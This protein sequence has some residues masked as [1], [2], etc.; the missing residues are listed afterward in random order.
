MAILSTPSPPTPKMVHS[1]SLDSD[2]GGT[3]AE[4]QQSTIVIVEES[5]KQLLL[6][7]D[8]HNGGLSV[9]EGVNHQEAN[10]A[11]DEDGSHAT[12]STTK[13]KGTASIMS[14]APLRAATEASTSE[15]NGNL[16]R[17]VQAWCGTKMYSDLVQEGLEWLQKSTDDT[18]KTVMVFESPSFETKGS[19]FIN[20]NQYFFHDSP[21]GCPIP[22]TTLGPLRYAAT[23]GSAFPV[24]LQNSVPAGLV[25]HWKASMP[26]FVEPTFVH[27]LTPNDRICAYLPLEQFPHHVNDPVVHYHL[28]GKSA[29]PLMTN[30]TTNLLPDTKQVRPCI[31]KVNHSM[32]SRGIFIIRNDEDEAEFLDFLNETGNPPYVVSE[33]IQIVRNIACHFFIHPNG[34]IV[35]LGS[36][37]NVRLPDGTW[38]TDSTMAMGVQ[39]QEELQALQLPHARDVANYCLSLGFWGFCG[40]D[41]LIDD[42]GLGHVVDV[43]PRVTG[44]CPA[45]MVAQQLKDAFGFQFGLF[46][47]STDHAYPGSLTRLL[48][49]VEAHNTTH[50]GVSRIVL[51]SA[52][53]NSPDQTLLNIGVY[54]E[55]CLTHLNHFSRL[56]VEKKKATY[57]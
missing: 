32:G 30:R 20:S 10:K 35:W 26:K 5:L 24:Y 11:V 8:A 38:D 51:F 56:F 22:R 33:F 53:E 42:S 9:V 52:H 57:M 19:S 2:L 50:Q 40:I 12:L 1:D 15:D 17:G 23:A 47:R 18:Q 54:G 6:A 31:A 4:Q 49:E 41:V 39:H 3:T 43:N 27:T 34:D 16:N 48:A 7:D 14:S 28:A 46:R 55:D 21:P 37:E 44:T 25:E 29:I 36:S 45:L 13:S